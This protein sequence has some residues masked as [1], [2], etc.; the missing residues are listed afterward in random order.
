[1]SSREPPP[2]DSHAAV[3]FG[4]KLYVWGGYGK[5]V[6]TRKVETFDVS[7]ETWEQSRQLRG[8][9]PDGLYCM[10][11][12]REGEIAYSYAGR[13]DVN[14]DPTR[15]NTLHR[16]D[17]S[18]LE[19]RELVPASQP[20]NAPQKTS[21]GRILCF[22]Q[23]LVVHGGRTNE[24]RTGELHVFDLRKSEFVCAYFSPPMG[25]RHSLVPILSIAHH[26]YNTIQRH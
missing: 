13:T 15:F 22:N 14:P 1:M 3:S 10:G 20:S 4:Q 21:G 8:S 26:T 17:L 11:V 9:Y 7:S 6:Q 18:T 25:V 24:G 2:R 23:K 19:C 5:G 16:I 12:T